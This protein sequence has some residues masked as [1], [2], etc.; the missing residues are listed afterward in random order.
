MEHRKY[1]RYDLENTA[2]LCTSTFVNKVDLVNI[3]E[4]GILLSTKYP[5]SFKPGDNVR[6]NFYCGMT[7]TL[8]CLNAKVVRS[9]FNGNKQSV[10]VT[11]K[12]NI[13]VSMVCQKTEHRLVCKQLMKHA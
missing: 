12:P 6:I 9:F 5:S 8:C 4:N 7:D 2:L 11:F 3:S 10:A 13:N 1:P